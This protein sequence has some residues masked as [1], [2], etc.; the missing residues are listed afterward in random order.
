VL[1]VV[2]LSGLARLRGR[3]WA[4]LFFEMRFAGAAR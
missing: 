3:R 4:A 1:T 2:V